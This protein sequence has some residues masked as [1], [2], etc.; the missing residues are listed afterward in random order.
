MELFVRLR[1]TDHRNVILP[2]DLTDTEAR[3]PPDGS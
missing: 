1:V 3:M 2:R